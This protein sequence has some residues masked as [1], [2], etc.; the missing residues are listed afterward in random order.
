M[1]RSCIYLLVKMLSVFFM[2]T[3][4][5]CFDWDKFSSQYPLCFGFS[6]SRML[7]MLVL[8]I[9]HTIYVMLSL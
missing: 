3:I 8:E 6:R 4:H 9:F 7:V 1:K 5:T 2:I